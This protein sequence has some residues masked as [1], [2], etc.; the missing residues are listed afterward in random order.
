MTCQSS[1]R[2][3]RAAL[4]VLF[5]GAASASVAAQ[6]PAERDVPRELACGVQSAV[7]TPLPAMRIIGGN[8]PR[9]TQFAPGDAV[10]IN[11]GTAQSLKV[12]AEYF[13]RRVVADRFT[14]P[15]PKFFP[16]SIHT[17]GWLKITEAQADNAV[18]TITFTCGDSVIEGDYL[19]P[20]EAPAA[21]PKP[22]PEGKPD[23]ANPG[24][25][26]LADER[27]QLGAPGVLMVLDRGTDHGLK[28]GQRLTIFR[29]S[30]E[31]SQP[32]VVGTATAMVIR[33]DTSLIRIETVSDVVYVGDL[34]AIHR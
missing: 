12:G 34:V 30:K 6:D 29:R 3:R 15:R 5:C 33:G 16:V 22:L 2:A 10:R 24:Q 7:T 19:A 1:E 25:L 13:V 27:R 9:K 28:P 23:F 17:A 14:E 26:I 8:E 11:A 31:G 18:G 21:A 20:F 32:V 4:V